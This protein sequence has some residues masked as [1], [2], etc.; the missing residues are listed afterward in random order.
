VATLQTDEFLAAIG[1]RRHSLTLGFQKNNHS[2]PKCGE[3]W[4][5]QLVDWMIMPAR[6]KCRTCK[7]RFE[8]DPEGA[9]PLPVFPCDAEKSN[10]LS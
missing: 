4:Q 5:I 10:N 8:F 9:A 6:W 1:N 2:C 7:T 3:S